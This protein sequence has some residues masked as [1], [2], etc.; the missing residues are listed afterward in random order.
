MKIFTNLL[1]ILFL[2]RM[3]TVSI[4]VYGILGIGCENRNVSK[5]EYFV[6]HKKA[7]C[8]LSAVSA[9]IVLK[10]INHEAYSHAC[11]G[12]VHWSCD[13]DICTGLYTGLFTA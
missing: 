12:L 9:R 5:G 8:S 6:L 2:T 7:I 4:T 11:T 3:F 1:V 10:R 13:I